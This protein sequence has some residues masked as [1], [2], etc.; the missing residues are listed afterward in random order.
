MH[1]LLPQH[2]YQKH[3]GVAHERARYGCS[4][5]H[6]GRHRETETKAAPPSCGSGHICAAPGAG[7]GL[8]S[9]VPLG[10]QAPAQIWAGFFGV[11]LAGG[12]AMRWVVIVLLSLCGA[13]RAQHPAS[14]SNMTLVGHH[15]LQGRSAYQPIIR[16]PA[17]RR[18]DIQRSRIERRFLRPRRALRGPFLE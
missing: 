16:E 3:F 6:G 9:C 8:I 1:R 18:R 17:G 11:L 13:A 15:D 14:A 5:G 7:G 10:S 4:F 2:A 12:G